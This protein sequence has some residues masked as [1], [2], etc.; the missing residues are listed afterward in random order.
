MPIYFVICGCLL[1][2]SSW[3]SARSSHHN[4]TVRRLI[5]ILDGVPYETIAELKTEGRFRRFKQPA[6]LISTFP[7]LTN[8]AMVEILHHEDS[9]GYE[10]HYYDRDRNRLLGTIQDRFR[11]EKFI[12]GTF[13]ETFDYHAAAFNGAVGYLAAPIGT[14]AM[15]QLD[16]AELRAAFLKSSA[17]LFVGYIGETDSLAHLGGK[18][19]LKAFLRTIAAVSRR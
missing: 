9:P 1:P 4:S 3:L 12:A 18:E 11:G 16:L 5:I 17:P 13:R 14:A 15:A 6:R 19:Q 2:L 7:S 8:V 10:D